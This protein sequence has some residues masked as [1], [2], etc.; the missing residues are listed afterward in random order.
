M[1][2]FFV[3]GSIVAALYGAPAFAADMPVKAPPM[4]T[5]ASVYSW[6]G[7]YV[8]ANIGG[9]W[10]TTNVGFTPNDPA[11]ATLFVAGGLPPGGSLKTSGVL[12]GPQLGYNWQV[13]R[14]WLVGVETDF[15]WSGIEGSI[16]G[17]NTPFAAGPLASME[18]ERLR[19][20]G[21]ARARLGYLPVDRLLTY[22]TGGFAYGRID[23][24][25]SYVNNGG[26]LTFTGAPI[27]VTCLAGAPCYAG[28]SASTATGWTVGAGF[29]YALSNSLT[30]KAEYLYVSLGA[31]SL[32]EMAF[33]SAPGPASFQCELRQLKFQYCARRLQ[34]SLLNPGEAST[35]WIVLTVLVVGLGSVQQLESESLWPRPWC[36]EVF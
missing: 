34:L 10:G 13:N 35:T 26:N 1:R 23:H 3:A 16:S 36:S 15:E 19:W 32:R 12:G 14:N 21:T 18:N 28:S 31:T 6:T 30:V 11:T 5:S 2:K 22:V 29:E 25:G 4:P 17:T 27:T 8:G 24:S 33:L 20:F 7:F 9:G